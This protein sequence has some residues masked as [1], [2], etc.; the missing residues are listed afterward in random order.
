MGKW[1]K[2]LLEKKYRGSMTVETAYL[3]PLFFLMFI[4]IMRMTFYFHD[5]TILYGA[6]YETAAEGV[7]KLRGDVSGDFSLSDY[8]HKRLGRKMIYFGYADEHISVGEDEIVVEASAWRKR[9]GISVRVKMSVTKPEKQLRMIQGL[10]N[11]AEKKMIQ[12][13]RGK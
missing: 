5:K 4:L 6:A 3:M 1:K 10:K 7:E 13:V 9:M 11:A 2:K 12:N 8:F